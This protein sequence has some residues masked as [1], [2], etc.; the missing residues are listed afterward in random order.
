MVPHANAGENEEKNSNLLSE[1]KSEVEQF[2]SLAN[3]PI[4]TSSPPDLPLLTYEKGLS[5]LPAGDG[6]SAIQT[7]KELAR[8]NST[9]ESFKKEVHATLGYVYLDRNRA[10]EALEE[11]TLLEKQGLF[12]ERALFG[13]AWGFLE[14]EEYV[15]AI[16]VFEEL[17][18]DYPNGEYAPEA[19]SKIGYCYSRLLAYK[20]AV[21]SYQKALHLYNKRLLA[22]KNLLTAS[23]RPGSFQRTFLFTNSDPEWKIFFEEMRNDRQGAEFL[24][25]AEYFF[26]LEERVYK[27][28]VF[29]QSS[30][31]YRQNLSGAKAQIQALFQKFVQEQIKEKQ[32]ITEDLSTE[33]AI[34]LARNMILEQSLPRQNSGTR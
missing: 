14:L 29:Q 34:E 28:P 6:S 2:R 9:P 15:K 17:L 32:Q 16:A 27:N 11:F 1:F 12:R 30:P 13:I 26:S 21:K 20:Y 22:Q 23:D 18:N 25:G 7:L 4:L 24:Y 31:Q 3:E 19:Y 5:L 33:A 10:K 8:S